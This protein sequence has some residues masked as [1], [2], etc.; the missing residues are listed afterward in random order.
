MA[1]VGNISSIS[2]VFLTFYK[3]T[4]TLF[5]PCEKNNNSAASNNDG[6]DDSVSLHKHDD[7]SSPAEHSV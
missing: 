3:L 4:F 2:I 7:P 1:K 5:R 6:K